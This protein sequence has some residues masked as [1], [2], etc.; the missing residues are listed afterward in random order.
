MASTTEELAGQAEQLKSTI[1]FF[2][3]DSHAT[4]R[5]LPHRPAAHH[6]APPS[7]PQVAHAAPQK[8]TNGGSGV[9]IELTNPANRDEM[10]Y[11][12]EKF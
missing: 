2:S 1:A 4:Q 10:D 11:E 9:R 5:A 3:I 6:T 7:R 8:A 12:F